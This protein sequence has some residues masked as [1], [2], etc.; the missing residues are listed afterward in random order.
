MPPTAAGLGVPVLVTA[1]SQAA[2]SGVLITVL[3]LAE[4]G[5]VLVDETEEVAVIGVA[6]TVDAVFTTTMMFADALRARLGLVQVT[7]PV[8]PTAGVVQVQPA[9]AETE[10]NVVLAGTG[11]RKLTPLAAPGPLLVIDWM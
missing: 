7:L 3:L 8:P 10:A 1:K 6:K 11:S 4:L 9:G 5:S 2:V